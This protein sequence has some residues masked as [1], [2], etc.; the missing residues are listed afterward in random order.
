MKYPNIIFFRFN[1]YSDIDSCLLNKSYNCTFNITDNVEDLNRLFNPNYHLLITFGDT[2]KEYHNIILPNIVNRFANRW[3]HKSREHILNIE[4]FNSTINYCYI[5]NVIME[6]KIQRPEFSVFTTCYNTWDKFDRVYNSLKNQNLKDWEWVIIDDTPLPENDK[7][8]H[9]DFLR[10]KCKN[11]SRIR[12]YC[13]SENSGNIGNVK[14]EAV[15]LCRGKYIL[16]LDHDDEILPDCLVDAAEV[17]DKDE[18]VGFVYMDFINIYEDGRNFSYGDFICKGYGG[19]YFQKY[20]DKWVN[21]YITPNINNI[22][23]SHL[24]CCPNHPRIWRKSVLLRLENYSEFL[25][26]C[27]DYEILLKTAL[28]TK[29]VKIHKLGY[30]QYMNDGNNNFSLIRNGEINRI[31]PY[32]IFPQFYQMYNVNNKMKHRDAY[33]DEKFIF[34]HS[35]I[36]KR[37]NYTHQYCNKIVNLDYKKQYCLIGEDALEMNELS[38]LYKDKTN[39]FIILSNRLEIKK[40]QELLDSKGY[41]DMRC[42]SLLD[43]SR[44]ELE[45]YFM[46]LCKC[47]DNYEILYSNS[48]LNNKIEKF[49]ERH[50]IINNYIIKENKKSYLEIGIENGYTFTNV[51]INDKI[52]VDPDPKIESSRIIKKTSDDFF[53]D[54]NKNFDI[55]FIDGMHQVEYILK[56]FNNSVKFLNKNG[57]IFLDDVLPI[58]KDEQEKIP[59]NPIYENGILKYSSPW[60]GDVWKFVYYLLLNFKDKIDYRV[61]SHQNY[62]GVVKICLKENFT[63]PESTLPIINSLEYDTDFEKYKEIINSN[64]NKLVYYSCYF[65]DISI[66]NFII[67]YLPSKQYDCYYF[68]NNKNIIELLKNTKWI[69]IYINVELSKDLT[70]NCEYSKHIKAC[71]HEYVELNKYDYLCYLDS[72][73]NNINDNIVENLIYNNFIIKK[74]GIIFSKHPYL[75]SS[76]IWD[77]YKEAV[78]NNGGQERYIKQKDNYIKYINNQFN[79]GLL[80][81]VNKLM[82]TG[83]ILRNNNNKVVNE[84][85]NIWYKHIK[86]CGIECQIS[87]YFVKQLFNDI[88]SIIDYNPFKNNYLIRDNNIDSISFYTY[89]KN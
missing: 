18:E 17:F 11:D 3:I 2:E 83:F 12:L 29:I 39:S 15:S 78:E 23:L 44:E 68:T 63:I 64:K 24:V 36:W 55:I 51:N 80:N 14:N 4:E 89:P 10:E 41:G 40:L 70:K 57:I 8:N 49:S 74:Y 73:N 32:H 30:I 26:I 48:D 61:F 42:Y 33:E 5:N 85:N 13:R 60:T 43:C 21:V 58:S 65:G 87:I 54:N 50:Y 25:P 62:R 47:C 88:I 76:N 7:K 45:R 6:R 16:E 20:K 69:A 22:T 31:G 53:K 34:N 84:F 66:N 77:E 75:S 9:F 46:L 67:P 72:K 35:Q 38:E 79:N 1:K 59:I 82:D 86:E 52:G 81:N 28:N 19:Y 71:P 37:E 56:D 27:D